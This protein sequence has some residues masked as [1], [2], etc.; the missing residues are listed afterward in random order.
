MP[1]DEHFS[2]LVPVQSPKVVL[3]SNS[4]SQEASNGADTSQSIDGDLPPAVFQLENHPI[5][6]S[7]G[8]K[9][10][11]RSSLIHPCNVRLLMFINRL[12]S[13][14]QAFQVS[15]LEYS[16]LSKFPA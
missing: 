13:L 16:Y 14:V 12:L 9:V 11:L 7:P 4:I 10:S 1:N 5:D 6:V 2:P 15:L 8:L 3:S